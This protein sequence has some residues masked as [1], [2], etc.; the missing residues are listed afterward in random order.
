[1]KFISDYIKCTSTYFT[2]AIVESTPQ[3]YFA[4]D[5]SDLMKEY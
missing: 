4:T 2:Y 3:I 5:L 1:M